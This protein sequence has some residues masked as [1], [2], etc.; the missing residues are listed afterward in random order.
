MKQKGQWAV[1][2]VCVV[3]GFMLAT[4]LRVQQQAAEDV[5]RQRS[6]ELV[7]LLQRSE[8]EREKLQEE[9]ATLRATLASVSKQ[10]EALAGLAAELEAAQ[11]LAG[12]M[13]MHGP[14]VVVVL[15]DSKRP[16][17]PGENPNAFILHD[18]DL[19]RVVNE[20]AAAGAEAVSING[21]RLVSTSEIRCAGPVI[22]I[23]GVRTSPPVTIM[24][25][26]D[27]H[28]LE[29]ALRLRGG[30]VDSLS[31]WGIQVQ[32][33]REQDVRV[34]AYQRSIGFSF[35]RPVG[36]EGGGP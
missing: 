31:F 5:S 28:D 30:V 15:D 26:G 22:S 36:G 16:S 33:R 13:E 35:A 1:A 12:L 7:V 24:A 32:I 8:R 2:L 34:P 19:L 27:P 3:L 23:N 20:L 14:G 6:Q 18:E 17:R 4:Q 29:S 11:M 25:I 21:Q 9:A 10:N